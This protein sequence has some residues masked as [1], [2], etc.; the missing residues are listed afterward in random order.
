MYSRR[1]IAGFRG[2]SG[3]F[4]CAVEQAYS[5]SHDEFIT[6][7]SGGAFFCALLLFGYLWR[8]LQEDE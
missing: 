3:A 6:E 2:F 4:V 8:I 7:G 1:A 5:F